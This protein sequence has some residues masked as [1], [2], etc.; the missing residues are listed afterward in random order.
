MLLDNCIRLFAIYIAKDKDEVINSFIDNTGKL[1]RFKDINNNKMTDGYLKEQITLH[2]KRFSTVYN[3]TSGYIHFSGKSMYNIFT[4]E[5]D[6][7][8]RFNIG[9]ELDQ[10]CDSDLIECIN[11]FI[12]YIEFYF[13]LFDSIINEKKRFDKEEFNDE[14][15]I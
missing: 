10:K 4:A 12:Y 8:I 11:A 1:Y 5:D 2:D 7:T 3:E 9:T 13:F 14:I 15:K 6:G